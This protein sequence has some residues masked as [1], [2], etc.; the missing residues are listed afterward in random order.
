MRPLYASCELSL[1]ELGFFTQHPEQRGY[2][3]IVPVMLGFGR[4]PWESIAEQSLATS[5]DARDNTWAVLL[6]LPHFT[7]EREK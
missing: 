3:L 5:L 6:S 7:S 2:A 1:R 4:H